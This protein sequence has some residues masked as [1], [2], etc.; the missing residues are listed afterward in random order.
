MRA[1]LG[2]DIEDPRAVMA[3]VRPDLTDSERISFD[4]AVDDDELQISVGADSLGVLRG[5]VNTA[6]ML[7]KLSEKTMR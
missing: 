1:D 7:T 4:I 5:G 3:A 6:L 2:L